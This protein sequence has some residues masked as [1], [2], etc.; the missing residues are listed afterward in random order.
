MSEQV[1]LVSK[2]STL[3]MLMWPQTK[4]PRHSEVWFLLVARLGTIL[5]LGFVTLDKL[6]SATWFS[7]VLKNGLINLV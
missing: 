5:Q 7:T 1:G 2:P 3:F 4:T 6:G